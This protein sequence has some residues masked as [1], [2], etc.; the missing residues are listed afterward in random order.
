MDLFCSIVFVT[1]LWNNWAEI[2]V[3]DVALQILIQEVHQIVI[4]MLMK[5]NLATISLITLPIN[6]IRS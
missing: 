5:L 1:T 6:E 3:Y 2:V 4:R